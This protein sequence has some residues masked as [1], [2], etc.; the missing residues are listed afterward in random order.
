[1]LFTAFV[2]VH[3]ECVHGGGEEEH[4][5]FQRPAL[6]ILLSCAPSCLLR[7]RLSLNLE[8]TSSA[9][10]WGT[11]Y[12]C[13]PHNEVTVVFLHAR[14]FTC[15]LFTCVLENKLR[16][17][18]LHGKYLLTVHLPSPQN[19]F[20]VVSFVMITTPVLSSPTIQLNQIT[21]LYPINV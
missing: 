6:S 2:Y 9:S 14:L 21:T 17:L 5:Y 20:Q 10:P 11:P 18:C 19:Y 13:L 1:M 15:V 7:Q 3:V 4:T 8:F 16:S 12:L